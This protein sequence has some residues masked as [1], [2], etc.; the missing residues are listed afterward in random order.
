MRPGI[1]PVTR[2]PSEALYDLVIPALVFSRHAPLILHA[3]L[4]C[5]S[6]PCCPAT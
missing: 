5:A 2:E 4:P 6:L 1:S 3:S